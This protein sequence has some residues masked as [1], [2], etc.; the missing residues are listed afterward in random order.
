MTLM[1]TLPPFTALMMFYVP[2]TLSVCISRPV[3]TAVTLGGILT[4]SV[5]LWLETVSTRKQQNNRASQVI[6]SELHVL[7]VT[8]FS[9]N[10]WMT[11]CNQILCDLISTLFK[12]FLNFNSWKHVY[13]L[14]FFFFF[15]VIY[16]CIWSL[17]DAVIEKQFYLF[18]FN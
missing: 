10:W 11:W 3:L 14:Y 6:L 5:M 4:K 13:M 16:L 18:H 15:N 9:V 1:T 17:F 7:N 2:A 8:L 12:R